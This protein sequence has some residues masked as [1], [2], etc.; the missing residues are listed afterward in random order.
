MLGDHSLVWEVKQGIWRPDWR[1]EAGQVER[2]GV[3]RW[4]AEQGW[5]FETGKSRMFSW[6]WNQLSSSERQGG[7][8]WKEVGQDGRKSQMLGLDP[9][10]PWWA[11]K[12][13]SRAV[14]QLLSNVWLF[15]TPWACSPP[16]SS[17]LGTFPATMLEWV[18][19]SFFRDLSNLGTEPISQNLHWQAEEY[20]NLT[21]WLLCRNWPGGLWGPTASPCTPF[22]EPEYLKG[23]VSVANPQFSGLPVLAPGSSGSV[24][25]SCCNLGCLQRGPSVLVCVQVLCCISWMCLLNIEQSPTPYHY[26]GCT[27]LHGVLSFPPERLE[28]AIYLFLMRHQYVLCYW[29]SFW[30]KL[31]ASGHTLRTRKILSVKNSTNFHFPQLL[32]FLVSY[33]EHWGFIIYLHCLALHCKNDNI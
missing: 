22:S 5:R 2:R 20:W 25:W 19:I 18:A 33:S 10:G 17:V 15:A 8:M 28:A 16:H 21:P 31:P 9:L 26:L 29:V 24:S 12:N 7:V 11:S 4:Q 6:S 3:H 13:L 27:F 32:L 14:V 30:K 1:L 23:M